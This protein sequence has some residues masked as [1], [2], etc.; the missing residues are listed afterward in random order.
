MNQIGSVVSQASSG[1]FLYLMLLNP[2]ATFYSII[3]GQTGTDG[4]LNTASQWFGYHESSFI[5][6]HWVLVSM[7]VQ[8][9]AALF[10][11][12]GAVKLIDPAVK[13]GRKTLKYPKHRRNSHTQN[14]A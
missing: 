6:D 13:K 10:L 4:V 9:L 14:D 2:A 12:S 7:A 5:T 3:R 11:N 1:G 8:L